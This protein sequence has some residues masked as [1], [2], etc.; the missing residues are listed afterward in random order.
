MNREET[1]YKI[2]KIIVIVLLLLFFLNRCRFDNTVLKNVDMEPFSEPVQKNLDEKKIVQQNF[3]DGLAYVTLVAKYKM[4]GRVYAKRYV[5]SKLHLA[6]IVPYDVT[7]G[8]GD[9]KSKDVYK[10]IKTVMSGRVV[11]WF[12]NSKCPLNEKEINSMMS[13]N[14]LIPANKNVKKGIKKLRKTDVVY[15]E[16]Y[17]ANVSIHKPHIIERSTSSLTRDDTGLGACEMI[18]VTRIVSRHGDF[19]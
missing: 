16:G 10:T 18:Y 4:Y 6:S 15:I 1:N 8:W 3:K 5:P 2:F 7:I 9:L 17:L 13:N 11:Y 14:H 12:Y 19:S